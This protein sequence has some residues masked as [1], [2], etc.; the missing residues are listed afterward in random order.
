MKNI[1]NYYI[2]DKGNIT[3]EKDNIITLGKVRFSV[4]SPRLI[5]IEY[6]EKGVFE[7]RATSLVSNRHFDKMPFGIVESETTIQINTGVFTLTYVKNSPI[8]VNRIKA[9]LNGTKVEWNPSSNEVKNLRSINYSLDDG[10]EKIVLDKGLYSLEGYSLLNDSKSLVLNEQDNF[11]SRDNAFDYYLFMYGSD[12]EGALRDYFTLTGY[13]EMIPR[14]ALGAWW[15]KNDAYKE[16]DIS[17]LVNSF[18]QNDIPLSVFILG[19]SLINGYKA[20]ININNVYNY[21]KNNNIKLGMTIN[22]TAYFDNN[23]NSFIPFSNNKIS[24]YSKNIIDNYSNLGIEIFSINYNNRLDKENLWKLDHYHSGNLKMKGKRTIILSRNHNIAMHRYPI[25]WSGKT[26]VNWNILNLLPRYNLQGYNMGISYIAHPIG[27]YYGGNEDDELY[28]R[29]I[30]FACFSPIFLMASEKGQYYKREP[31]KWNY[32]LRSHITFYINLRYK[33]IPYL[34]S[35]SYRYH[36]DGKGLVKPFYFDY[37]K[38]LDEPLYQNQYFLGDNFFV[39]PITERKNRVINRVFKKVFVPKGIW[40]DFLKGKKYIGDKSYNSFYRD[41]DYPVFVKAGSIIPIN[42]NLKEVIPNTLE[43]LIYPLD[44]GIYNLYED[45]GFSYTYEKGLYMITN[46]SYEYKKDD[47]TLT[48]KKLEGKNLL[49]RRNYLLRFKN[50]RNI[51][52]INI[53]DKMVKYN[54]YYDG[55]D[56]VIYLEGLMIGKDI[57][58]NIKGNN[59]FINYVTYINE[60]IKEI[61]YDIELDTELK[62]IIDSILFSN[63]DIRKK[64]IKIKKLKKKG[65]ESKYIKVFIYLLEYIQ[66]I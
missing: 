46:F 22:P 5:R 65:L 37:P 55:D 1:S 12:F 54:S 15:Y 59:T 21:L 52:Q 53:D 58:I 44:N 9:I 56:F 63:L 28:L 57:R 20:N 62:N 30:Q 35:E 7:D 11:V 10:E 26:K 60:E 47:Y 45:D 38:V 64:R 36:K 6:S 50:I 42:N 24:L 40:F 32:I 25:M 23:K 34:Y 19:E 33:L 51:Q 16:E 43:L 39:A 14:Y 3:C 27:G 66:K 41:E 2:N 4:L 8:K 13:P 29:Y 61:L 49:S 18:M 48:I 17:F 31:W